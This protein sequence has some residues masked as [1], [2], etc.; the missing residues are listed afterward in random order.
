MQ[1]DGVRLTDGAPIHLEACLPN[2]LRL[3]CWSQVVHAGNTTRVVVPLELTKLQD[4]EGVD[5]GQLLLA[6]SD[7]RASRS[8]AA[9]VS[10]LVEPAAVGL[11]RTVDAHYPIPSA[12]L[13]LHV[14]DRVHRPSP[15]SALR[16]FARSVSAPEP[17]RCNSES[18]MR[19]S[20]VER[21]E[22]RRRQAQRQAASAVGVAFG[23]RLDG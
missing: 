6:P 11:P 23:G 4:T 13:V 2:A 5:C 9:A 22:V 14:P 7:R 10:R 3:P 18:V 8:L 12:L 17:G 16:S 19:Y 21:G 1:T 15:A 20:A